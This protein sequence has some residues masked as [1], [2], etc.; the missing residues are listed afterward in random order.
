MGIYP[1]SLEK[2]IEHLSRLPGIGQKSASRIAL[3]VLRS[4]RQL[5]EDLAGSLIAVKDNIRLCSICFNITDDDPCRIC[6]DGNR[7]D[8]TL[9][10]VEGPGDQLA[11]EEAGTFRGRYHVLHGVLSPL[12]G[13]GPKDLKINELLNRITEEN[14]REVILATNPTTEGETTASYIADILSKN[15]RN[16]KI[17]RI[18]LGVPMGGDL[19]Y[20][21]RMTLE[22]AMKSRM[23][24]NL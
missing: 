19:K 10:V 2:L 17:T 6:S 9:C 20:M 16:L 21:D 5:S 22:H 1:K 15:G 13:I 8:G 12:D 4:D 24:V 7:A 18:A 11:I 23:P 14:V 3:Y